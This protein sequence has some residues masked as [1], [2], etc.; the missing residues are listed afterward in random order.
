MEKHI[1]TDRVYKTLGETIILIKFREEL[2]GS[3]LE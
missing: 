2:Y 3:T 1:L